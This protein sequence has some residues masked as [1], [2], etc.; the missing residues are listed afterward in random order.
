MIVPDLFFLNNSNKYASMSAYVHS[1]SSK[2]FFTENIH[3]VWNLKIIGSFQTRLSD[4]PGGT[5]NLRL[6]VRMD[7]CG[8]FPYM[9]YFRIWNGAPS[10]DGKLLCFLF[11]LFQ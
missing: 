1:F 6:T 7:P 8:R 10:R 11:F 4:T 3:C 9:V 2:T 5:A